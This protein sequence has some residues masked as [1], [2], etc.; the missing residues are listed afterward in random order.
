[1]AKMTNF[2]LSEEKSEE[3][4][5]NEVREGKIM[6]QGFKFQYENIRVREEE[7]K[8]KVLSEKVAKHYE[9]R[10]EKSEDLLNLEE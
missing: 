6:T 4:T 5:E 9:Q 2:L 3:Q 7:N 1:M 10:K 8:R